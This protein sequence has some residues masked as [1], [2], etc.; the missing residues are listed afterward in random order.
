MLVLGLDTAGEQG[1][2]GL[3]DA[4]RPRSEVVFH[5][6]R[7]HGELL[8][9]AIEAA[10][11]LGGASRSDLELIAVA[12]GPGSFTG[13]RIGIA[14]AK[15]LA[16]ALGIP[17]VGVPSAEVYA[18]RAAF[19]PGPVW[20]LLP[21]RR[22]RLYV[23]SFEDGRELEPLRAVRFEGWLERDLAGSGSR[24][25]SPL[26]IGPEAERR[27]EALEPWG[28]VPPS[29]LHRPSGV[30]VARRGLEAYRREE[31]DEF[32]ELEPLYLHPALAERGRDGVVAR[33]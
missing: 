16:R 19:W 33:P 30:E 5:A 20:V 28:V 21:D 24:G 2:V 32:Y 4:E 25:G 17:L 8:L 18:R 3:I 29:P 10:L 27:R 9:S 6:A 15:G 13:L 31:R 12:E 23:G 7:R 11:K 14:T 22:D 1:C 26:F